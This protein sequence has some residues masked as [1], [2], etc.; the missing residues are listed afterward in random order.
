[1][2]AFRAQNGVDLFSVHGERDGLAFAA[3]EYGGDAAGGAQTASF[4]FSPLRAGSCFY[5]NFVLVLSHAFYLFFLFPEWPAK[6]GRYNFESTAAQTRVS[7][8]PR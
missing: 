2:A 7:V 3:V 5:Y 6:A 8:L 4:V 1:V